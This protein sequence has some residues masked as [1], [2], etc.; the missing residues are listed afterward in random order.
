MTHCHTQG[1]ERTVKQYMAI[2]IFSARLFLYLTLFPEW[3][4]EEL[5]FV[6]SLLSQQWDTLDWSY[7]LCDCHND[8]LHFTLVT[9]APYSQNLAL[10]DFC[11]LLKLKIIV[12]FNLCKKKGKRQQ[13][14][15]LQ[16][17]TGGI[18]FPLTPGKPFF[19]FSGKML[20]YN[21]SLLFSCLSVCPHCS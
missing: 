19:F 11:I 17:R 15:K 8:V 12:V 21:M 16:I 10:C 13:N 9:Q 20:K 1:R 7:A 2:F 18:W 14:Q 6:I 3:P 4:K 5:A